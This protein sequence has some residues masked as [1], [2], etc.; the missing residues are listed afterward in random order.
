MAVIA[1]RSN[2]IGVVQ[3]VVVLA[4]GVIVVAIVL[5]L[6]LIPS[7]RQRSEGAERSQA[8]VPDRAPEGRRRRHQPDLDQDVGRPAQRGTQGGRHC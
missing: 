6:D 4:V 8:A 3:W 1:Q 2:R 5:G 7:A